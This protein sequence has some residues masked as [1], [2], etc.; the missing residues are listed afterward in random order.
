MRSYIE[1][2]RF[3]S[4]RHSIAT[5]IKRLGTSEKSWNKIE[6]AARLRSEV[7]REGRPTA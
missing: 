2:L 1:A 6:S 7:V 3:R 4:V 5:D